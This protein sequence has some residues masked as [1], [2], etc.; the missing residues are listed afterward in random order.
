MFC[1]F[2]VISRLS[3]FQMANPD[4]DVRLTTA[5]EWDE[6]MDWDA[7]IRF[8]NG[9]WPKCHAT[10]LVKNV[11]V[12]VCRPT[13]SRRENMNP[14]GLLQQTLLNVRGRPDDWGVWCNAFGIDI[15]K[16][17]HRREMESSA[18]AYQAALEGQ[19]IALAQKVLVEDDLNSGMLIAMDNY[20]LDRG[21]LTYYLVWHEGCPKELT[22]K[23][24]EAWL[25]SHA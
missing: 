12:P 22:L 4:I 17:S 16:L 5:S 3:K 13:E 21:A 10:P 1:H 8:G 6:G 15:D 2:F 11:L 24:L 14:E 7:A 25:T 18:L 19:G 23:R 9:V 20:Q